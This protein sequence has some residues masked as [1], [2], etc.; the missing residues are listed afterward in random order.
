M[1]DWALNIIVIFWYHPPE[2]WEYMAFG[3]NFNRQLLQRFNA[4]GI[5]FAFPSQTVYISP[6]ERVVS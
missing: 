1:N 2:Y 5:S 3:D 4:A 6:E